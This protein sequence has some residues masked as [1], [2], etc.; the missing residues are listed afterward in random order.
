MEDLTEP[1]E[2]EGPRGPGGPKVVV[3]DGLVVLPGDH[4]LVSLRD[5]GG[6]TAEKVTRLRDDLRER[7][8]GVEVT[9]LAGASVAV[10]RPCS[11]CSAPGPGVGGS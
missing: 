3:V 1:I 6:L 9:L 2:V 11:A 5:H 4:L 10:H 8:P 7:F